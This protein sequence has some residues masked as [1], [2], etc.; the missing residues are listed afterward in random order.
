[1][2]PGW[3]LL[4]FVVSLCGVGAWY[5]RH[6]TQNVELLRLLAGVGIVSMISLVIWTWQGGWA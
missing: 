5:V 6:F 3:Y 4:L 2:P 1:M